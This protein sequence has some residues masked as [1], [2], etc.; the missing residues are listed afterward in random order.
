M[1]TEIGRREERRESKHLCGMFAAKATKCVTSG[2]GEEGK[3]EC[4]N[5]FP[6]CRY[7]K[8]TSKTCAST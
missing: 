6:V 7:D 8:N 3:R 1:D 4:E 5:I 2:G